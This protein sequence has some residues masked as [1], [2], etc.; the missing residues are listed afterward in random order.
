MSSALASST[1]PEG[2][3]GDGKTVEKADQ[4][5]AARWG[6][7][8]GGILLEQPFHD[9]LLGAAVPAGV[10]DSQ[11]G[12]QRCGQRIMLVYRHEPEFIE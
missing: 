9:P 4:Q 10:L 12:Q 3:A 1:S 7:I 11:F 8:F 6:E 5:S 2:A